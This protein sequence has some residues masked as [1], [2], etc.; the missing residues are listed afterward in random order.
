MDGDKTIAATFSPDTRDT[1]DDGLTNYQEIVDYGT[2]PTKQDT[3]G[4]GAK[5]AV[6]GRPLDPTEKLDTD[7]DGIGD[8]AD[9][10]DDG[11]GLSDEDEI[12]IHGTNPKRPDSDGDGLSDPDELQTHQTD[13]NLADTDGDGL[14]DGAEFLTH[15]TNPKIGDTDGDGFL[16]GYEVLTGK[17]PL[18]ILDKPVLMAEARTAIE[19]TFPSAIGKIYRIED[20]LDLITW[21]TVESG[22]AGNGGQI[23]RFY[24]TRSLPKRYFRVEEDGL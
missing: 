3:D 23:Q 1:D 19:F 12:N 5:D 17:S 7:A 9:T 20:S 4:D 15:H 13:P 6:D 24:S 21:G 22:I 11:D 2:D 18:N 14:S 8:N 10:D 16:D